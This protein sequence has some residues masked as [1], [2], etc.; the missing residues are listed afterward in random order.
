MTPEPD[1]PP[2]PPDLLTFHVERTTTEIQT[3][4]ALDIAAAVSEAEANSGAWA[5]TGEEWLV[6]PQYP[7]D[8]LPR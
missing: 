8:R 4:E 1:D 7:L 6:R 5:L 2:E 3:V